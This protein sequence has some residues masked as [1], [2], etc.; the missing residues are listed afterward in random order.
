M[1]TIDVTAE[2]AIAA[3]PTDVAGVMFDPN[4]DREWMSLVTNV[5]VL[6]A[7]IKP[8]A[9]V[10]RTG[11]VMGRTVTWTTEVASFHFPHALSLRVVD[12]PFAGSVAYSVQRSGNGS[13]ARVTMRLDTSALGPVPAIMVESPLQSVLNADLAKL[14]ALIEKK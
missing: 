2:T 4:R 5:E 6:D 14:K 8:G 11:T 12:A 7:A 1:P 3:E 10:R 13:S 9:R